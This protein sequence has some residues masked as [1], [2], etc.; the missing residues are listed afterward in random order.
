VQEEESCHFSSNSHNRP[1]ELKQVAGLGLPL[2]PLPQ[3]VVHNFVVGRSAE[4]YKQ[5][6]SFRDNERKT[7]SFESQT[8]FFSYCYKY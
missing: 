1:E 5:T 8:A 4:I 6:I 2:L 7:N 3:W